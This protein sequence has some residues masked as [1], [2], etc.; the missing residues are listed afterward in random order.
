MMHGAV[1]DSAAPLYGR[2]REILRIGPL[3]ARWIRKALE[4]GAEEA[5]EAYAIWGGLPRN[6]E[7]AA[8]YPSSTDALKALILD[9]NGVLHAEP[10]RLLLDDMRSSV[11]ANT[12]LSLIAAGCHR[13]GEVAGRLERPVTSL[14]RPLGLLVDLGYVK[15]EVPFG[16]EGRS[17]KRSLYRLADPFLSFWYRS[18]EANRSML[19]AGLVEPVYEQVAQRLDAHTGEVW[20]NLARESVRSLTIGDRRWGPASR[21][22]GRDSRGDLLEVD[23]VAD[24]LDRCSILIGEAA[25]S[26]S[27]SIRTLA[28]EVRAKS[29]RLP[30]VRGREVVHALWVRRPA[31]APEGVEVFGPDDVLGV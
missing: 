20:E 11:Q 30:F 2:A 3:E 27:G 15:R 13:I 22:W 23:V 14:T 5:V 1:L 25:W 19:E 9:P 28:A 8:E 21:W 7:L 24:S 10:P 31:R 26:R 17:T 6:W 4:L 18:V 29:A 12:I 16:E